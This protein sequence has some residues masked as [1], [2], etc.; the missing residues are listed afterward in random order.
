M[1]IKSLFVESLLYRGDSSSV[2][3][4]V[5]DK[6]E[7]E[8]LFGKGLYLTNNPKVARDYSNKGEGRL[9]Q[10]RDGN[11]KS[12]PG[13]LVAHVRRRIELWE[14]DNRDKLRE[15]AS[16]YGSKSYDKIAALKD[17]QWTV[18]EQE[19]LQKAKTGLYALKTTQNEITL[20]T[21]RGIVS[22][23]DIPDAYLNQTV[24]ADRP[25]P[26][27]VLKLILDLL[28][29][30]ARPVMQEYVGRYKR[31]AV[32]YAWQDRLV[33]GH[34]ANPTMD[35]FIHGT[36]IGQAL[37]HAKGW[38]PV[39]AAFWGAFRTA[40]QPLG[41]VGIEYRGGD[42]TAGVPHRAFVFW[43]VPTVNA[44]RKDSQGMRSYRITPA[45]LEKLF[46]QW[47]KA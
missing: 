22:V 30:A 9:I 15:L 27:N 42:R 4:F 44:F 12:V 41:Y 3:Q 13:A 46:L 38:P 18:I 14:G 10:S 2:Q 36:H 45:Y 23:F 31:E 24:N 37:T 34:G 32:P 26:D 39:E 29:D 25:M 21:K 20:S 1:Q 40:M 5:F 47:A 43:D 11:A 17:A 33:G 35:E 7:A 19:L 6:S 8:G 16:K 28:D